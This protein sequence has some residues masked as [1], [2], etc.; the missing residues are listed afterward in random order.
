MQRRNFIYNKPLVMALAILLLAGCKKTTTEITTSTND[1]ASQGTI[2]SDE[3]AVNNEMDQVVDEAVASLCICKQTSGS[4]TINPTTIAGAV[5]DTSQVDS[6]IVNIFYYGKESNPIK[7]RSGNVEIKLPVV[8]KHLIPWTT[9]GVT[10]AITITNYEIFY[11]NIA[12]KTLWFKGTINVSNA[13]GVLIKN[14]IVGDSLVEKVRGPVSFTF[15]DNGAILYLYLWNLHRT[16]VIKRTVTNDTTITTWGDTTI[17]GIANIANWGMTR[18]SNNYYTSITTPVFQ[19][20]STSS[21]Y[22]PLSG[23]KSIQSIP[24]PLTITYGGKSIRYPG[25]QQTLLDIKNDLDK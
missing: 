5:I 21:F 9:T 22:D 24:E 16:R 19:D 25:S 8:G 11:S 10:A 4:L 15:N 23:V 1:S 12:N 17:N 13:N 7:S 18:L 6:G 14:L 3:L 20:I 2:A